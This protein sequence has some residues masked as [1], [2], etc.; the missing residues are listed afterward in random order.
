[1]Q[2]AKEKF[3][4][5]HGRN[6]LDLVSVSEQISFAARKTLLDVEYKNIAY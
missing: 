5:N 3:S 6:I 4:D 1:M 2:L